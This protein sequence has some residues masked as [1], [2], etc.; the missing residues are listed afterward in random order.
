[1][2]AT[3]HL[4]VFDSIAYPWRRPLTRA[5]VLRHC[6]RARLSSIGVFPM[7]RN[8]SWKGGGVIIRLGR[9]PAKTNPYSI[10]D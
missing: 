9:T 7:N 6:A 1:V 2:R 4:D 10:V 3:A 5:Y 8:A